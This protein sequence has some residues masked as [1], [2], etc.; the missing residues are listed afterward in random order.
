M[1]GPEGFEFICTKTIT[2]ERIALYAKATDDDNPIHSDPKAAQKAGFPLPFAPG[3]LVGGMV[4]GAVTKH[5]GGNSIV[6]KIGE[7]TFN[8]VVFQDGDVEVYIKISVRRKV[9]AIV[10]AEVWQGEI[11][12]VLI[13]DIKVALPRE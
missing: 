3:G 13:K 9:S 12:H 2:A 7:I 1:A 8:K 11:K 6:M 10:D 4:S 5:F